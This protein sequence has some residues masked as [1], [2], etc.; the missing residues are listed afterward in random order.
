MHVERLVPSLESAYDEFSLRHPTSTL[1]QSLRYR[2]FLGKIIEPVGVSSRTTEEHYLV[3]VDADRVVGALP[4]FIKRNATYG[5]V[6]NSLPFVGSNGGV[7]V[8]PS[9]EDPQKVY[10]ALLGSFHELCASVDAVSSTIINRP[11]DPDDAFY[12]A[13]S[14]FTA[15]DERIG[16]VTPLP[17]TP[18]SADDDAI[19]KAIMAMIHQ[20]T[21]NVIRKAIGSDVSV[22]HS[23]DEAVLRR[24]HDIHHENMTAIGAPAKPWAVFEAIR[25]EFRY[26]DD[27]RV[28]VAEREGAVIAGLLVF[29]VNRVAEYFIP[30]T[31]SESRIFQ[32]QSLLCLR[33]MREARR[34]G[35]THWNWGGTSKDQTG[36]YGF[37]SRW[38]TLDLPYRYFVRERKPALRSLSGKTLLTEYPY[39]YTV[40]FAL[41]NAQD[42]A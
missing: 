24:L 13:H 27:Y 28:Y 15:T 42:R 20:K 3:A 39:F 26:D 16:Q 2:A 34:R 10:H 4:A 29:F 12:D 1:F 7:L 6:V 23:G 31:V 18:A 40:P 41:L 32:P 8:D 19:D 22:S 25:D 11:L 30:V 5:N 37:K 14:E 21:R 9:V 35:C 36:V 17:A 38:G 33:A